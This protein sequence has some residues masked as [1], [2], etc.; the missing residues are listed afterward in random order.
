MKKINI[1]DTPGLK[2]ITQS[3]EKKTIDYIKYA[4]LILFVIDATHLGQED[5]IEALDLLSEYTKPIIGVVN[6]CDL[7]IE[8]EVKS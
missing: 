1:V 3:N 7:L 4:D 8:I 5:T 6:K 2:S